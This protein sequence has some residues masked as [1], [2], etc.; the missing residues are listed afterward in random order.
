MSFFKNFS[1]SKAS[2]TAN[3]IEKYAFAGNRQE[4]S[5]GR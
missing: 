4:R 5:T 3:F 2:C 1:L